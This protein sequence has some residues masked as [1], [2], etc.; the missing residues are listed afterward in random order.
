LWQIG[1]EGDGSESGDCDWE[2]NEL[3][4]LSEL[5][6]PPFWMVFK[7]K[8]DQVHV[9]IHCRYLF[10]TIVERMLFRVFWLLMFVFLLDIM[11]KTYSFSTLS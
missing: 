9:Y 8:S 2:G 3:D 6:L 5:K 11:R 7:L 10:P 4:S 1:Y